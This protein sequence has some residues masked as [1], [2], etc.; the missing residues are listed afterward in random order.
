M[1]YELDQDYEVTI[2]LKRGTDYPG[3][4]YMRSFN[5]RFYAGQ[6]PDFVAEATAKEAERQQAP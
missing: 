5:Y 1:T 6:V 2:Y 4:P 3:N